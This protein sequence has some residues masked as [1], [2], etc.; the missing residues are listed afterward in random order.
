MAY[1][2]WAEIPFFPPEPISFERGSAGRSSRT[3]TSQE[4]AAGEECEQGMAKPP[5]MYRDDEIR[6][7]GRGDTDHQSTWNGSMDATSK[8]T[9]VIQDEKR[10]T[11]C[12]RLCV[13]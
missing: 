3:V 5:R 1:A 4:R 12:E 13:G 2:S 6:G 8:R 9:N 11:G 7:C 10:P